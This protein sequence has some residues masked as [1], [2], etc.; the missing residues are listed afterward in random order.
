V[1]QHGCENNSAIGVIG[2]AYVLPAEADERVCLL[3]KGGTTH[4]ACSEVFEDT[5]LMSGEG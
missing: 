4:D 1:G 3:G 2:C 5:C